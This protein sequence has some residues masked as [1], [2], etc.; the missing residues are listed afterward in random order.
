VT[1]DDMWAD[2][3]SAPLNIWV[4]WSTVTGLWCPTCNLPTGVKLSFSSDPYD[5][6][7]GWSYVC[8][9]DRTHNRAV[10]EANQ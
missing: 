9:E 3:E 7:P 1:D 6:E 10:M 4:G 2:L 8:G 5:P